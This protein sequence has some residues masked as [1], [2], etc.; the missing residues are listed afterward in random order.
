MKSAANLFVVSA[1]V[2]GIL[3]GVV[4][5]CPSLVLSNPGAAEW[6]EHARKASVLA[7]AKHDVIDALVAGRLTLTEA[8]DR[9]RA[10]NA[11]SP[12]PQRK[13]KPVASVASADESTVT[14]VLS[15]ASAEL[16]SNNPEK[17]EAVTERLKQEARTFLGQG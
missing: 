8:V 4:A 11:D 16:E 12:F 7:V 1:A 9:F 6:A 2:V 17:Q 10:L 3:A 15:W 14:E 13:S 5:A